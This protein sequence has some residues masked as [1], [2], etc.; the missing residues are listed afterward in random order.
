MQEQANEQANVSVKWRQ[1]L[2]Q[3]ARPLE[4]PLLLITVTLLYTDNAAF[5]QPLMQ[6]RSRIVVCVNQQMVGRISQYWMGVEMFYS[7][8]QCGAKIA[9]R[10]TIERS[11]R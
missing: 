3:G 8:Y 10:S 9:R 1:A 4:T 5:V 7:I 11:T 6:Q 2:Q